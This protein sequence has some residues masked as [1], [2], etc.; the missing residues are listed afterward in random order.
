[1]CT[2]K[3]ICGKRREIFP[4]TMP[5]KDHEAKKMSRI[6]YLSIDE[7]MKNLQVCMHQ[8]NM[9]MIGCPENA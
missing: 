2:R 3:Y 7:S 8:D 6:P 5:K 1:M 4:Q 9:D